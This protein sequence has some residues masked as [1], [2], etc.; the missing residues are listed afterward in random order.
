[1]DIFK[2]IPCGKIG[3]NGHISFDYYSRGYEDCV[4]EIDDI[5]WYDKLPYAPALWIQQ[6]KENTR[7]GNWWLHRDKYSNICIEYAVSGSAEYCIDGQSDILSSGEILLTYPGSSVTVSDHKGGSFHRI[8]VIIS[9]GIAKI[10]PETLGLLKLRKLRLE[11]LKTKTEFQNLLKAIF[12]NLSTQNDSDAENNS[13]L[14]YD[15]LLFLT[16]LC[17]L[18][19]GKDNELPDVLT[20]TLNRMASGKLEDFSIST[21]ASQAGVSRMTLTTLFRKHLNTTPLAYWMKLKMEHAKQL[22]V[23][24]NMPVKLISVDLGFKSQLYFSTVFRRHFGLSPTA[25]RKKYRNK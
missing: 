7:R 17:H 15:V 25:Y 24:S 14:A 6:Y 19:S 20:N 16:K 4:T 12:N 2:G 8:L 13:R 10:A 23:N 3:D 11:N 18:Q 21:L 5:R 1:M 9:G 22:L